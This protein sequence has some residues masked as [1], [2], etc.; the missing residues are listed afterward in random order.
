MVATR[1]RFRIQTS[2][3]GGFVRIRTGTGEIA[4]NVWTMVT[5]TWDG[6][7]ANPLNATS[8]YID[9][10]AA[11]ISQQGG[12]SLNTGDLN[13]KSR[14]QWVSVYERVTTGRS[15]WSTKRLYGKAQS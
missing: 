8:I 13:P 15:V 9:D 5:V 6:N 3:A 1:I 12:G 11:A 7:F 10:T 14:M 2:G 4:Q